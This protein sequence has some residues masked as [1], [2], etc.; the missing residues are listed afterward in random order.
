[1]GKLEKWL[2]KGQRSLLLKCPKHNSSQNHKWSSLTPPLRSK[3]NSKQ[4]SW[5][6]AYSNQTRD[7]PS[8]CLS[9]GEVVWT[10]GQE[11]M[12]SACL[13]HGE[14]VWMCSQE[15]WCLLLL[16]SSRQLRA[17]LW[18]PVGGVVASCLF[19]PLSTSISVLHTVVSTSFL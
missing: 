5:L 9:Q 3:Y 8:A 6:N 12:L 2:P 10:C 4:W 19:A 15:T 16:C 7:I 17:L 1:M 14:A 13:S 11:T 18:A